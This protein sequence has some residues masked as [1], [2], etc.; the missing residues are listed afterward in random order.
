MRAEAYR[1]VLGGEL[2]GMENALSSLVWDV[3]SRSHLTFDSGDVSGERRVSISKNDLEQFGFEVAEKV[4]SFLVAHWGNA[5]QQKLDQYENVELL[6][7][8]GRTAKAENDRRRA[9]LICELYKVVRPSCDAG[10]KGNGRANQIVADRFEMKTGQPITA[11]T[12][13]DTVK[14]AGLVR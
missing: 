12:V 8:E 14:K 11:R 13:R 1:E 3:A 10:R 6:T 7:A 4:V 9:D 5:V 2:E